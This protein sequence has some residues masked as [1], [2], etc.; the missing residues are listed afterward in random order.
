RTL[1]LNGSL[2]YNTDRFIGINSIFSGQVKEIG[3]T[4]APKP[5]ESGVLST[6]PRPIDFGDR[7]QEGDLLAVLWSKDLGQMKSQLVG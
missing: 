2:G 4:N 1:Q 6:R 3:T 5:D 7:V